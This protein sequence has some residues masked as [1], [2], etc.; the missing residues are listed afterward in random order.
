MENLQTPFLYIYLQAATLA[1]VYT[2]EPYGRMCPQYAPLPFN[3]LIKSFLVARFYKQRLLQST[4]DGQLE[5]NRTWEKMW[6]WNV[7]DAG[8]TLW[9]ACELL[10]LS[11][12]RRPPGTLSTRETLERFYCETGS[13]LSVNIHILFDSYSFNTF[14][15][16]ICHRN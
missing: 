5:V 15:C 4:C 8:A 16:M 9:A 11:R 1:C 12:V 6:L 10:R 3:W 2:C 13:W 14:T 7:T